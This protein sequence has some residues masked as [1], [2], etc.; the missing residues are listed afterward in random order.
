MFSYGV[1]NYSYFGAKLEK[2]I[3]KTKKND[4]KGCAKH[5]I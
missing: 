4:E 5:R 3:D 2:I 1:S